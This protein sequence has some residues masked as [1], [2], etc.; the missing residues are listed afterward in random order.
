MT[1]QKMEQY[2]DAMITVRSAKSADA[3]ENTGLVSKHGT[4]RSVR[5]RHSSKGTRWWGWGVGLM[6]LKRRREHSLKDEENS[7]PQSPVFGRFH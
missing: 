7:S 1:V 2:K 5:T 4:S 6:R 3:H